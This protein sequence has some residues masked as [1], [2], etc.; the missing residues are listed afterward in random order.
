MAHWPEEFTI[1][2]KRDLSRKR[3]VYWWG[4]GVSLPTRRKERTGILVISGAGKD[5]IEEV[6]LILLQKLIS[7]RPRCPQPRLIWHFLARIND[8]VWLQ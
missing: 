2:R 3:Y 4:R 1:W 6:T 7:A 8:H 5:G